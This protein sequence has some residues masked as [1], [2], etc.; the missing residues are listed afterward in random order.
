MQSKILVDAVAAAAMLSISERGFFLLLRKYPELAQRARVVLGP[1]AV[2]YR[3]E[4]IRDFV[5]N[6]P[7]S[8]PLPEPDRLRR[9]K[10][11]KCIRAD[12]AAAW[13][14]PS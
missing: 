13:I 12:V 8:E 14:K 1:R 11:S 10:E 2:R 7:V 3:V 4:E 5:A 9:A 6:L